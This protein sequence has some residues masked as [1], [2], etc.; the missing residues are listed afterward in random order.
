MMREKII[1]IRERY[2]QLKQEKILREEDI[3]RTQKRVDE[4][5]NDLSKLK[6]LVE[7]NVSISKISSSSQKDR[8]IGKFMIY[9]DDEKSKQ[10]SVSLG[11]TEKHK[12]VEDPVLLDYSKEKAIEYMLNKFPE[13]YK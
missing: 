4:I 13:K 6:W 11:T 12:G 10:V 1:H 9:V 8:Y 5:K 2:T 3:Q 7:P